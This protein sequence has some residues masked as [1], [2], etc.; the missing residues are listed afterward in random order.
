VAG[1]EKNRKFL[2]GAA[3]LLLLLLLFSAYSNSFYAPPELDDIHSFI[4]EP[5][6]LRFDF[7]PQAVRALAGSKFGI[8]RFLPML[9]LAIDQ[10]RGDG[11][12]AAFHVTNFVIHLLCSLAVFWWLLSVLRLAAKPAG[13]ESFLVAAVGFKAGGQARGSGA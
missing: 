3:F 8:C 12:L 13:R 10:W 6:V 4:D 2:F 5:L 9:T 11:S 7:S 1:L